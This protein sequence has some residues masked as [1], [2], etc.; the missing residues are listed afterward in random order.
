MEHLSLF[1]DLDNVTIDKKAVG[2]L[3]KD[4]CEKYKI[5]PYKIEGDVLYLAS[6]KQLNSHWIR[7]LKFITKKNIEIS[8]CDKSQIINLIN[9]YYGKDSADRALQELQHENNSSQ[10]SSKLEKEQTELLK[11]P[12]ITLVDSIVY[13]AVVKGASDIHIEPFKTYVTVRYRVDGAL[14]KF[15]TYPKVIY[16]SLTT[17]IKIIS[18]M[19]I[20]KKHYPQDGKFSKVIND[21]EFDFRVSSLPTVNGEKF[22]I[23]VLHRSD[24]TLTLSSLGFKNKWCNVIEELLKNRQGLI[25]ITGPTGSGK[26]TTLYSMLKHINTS[27]KNLVTVED[28]VEYVLEGVNQVHVNNQSGLTFANTLKAILRQDPD[29][30]MVGEIIDEAT[31]ETAIRAALTGHLVLTTLHTNDAA[32]TVN[33]LIDMNIASYLISDSLLAVVAQ[34]LARKVCKSC[35]ESYKPNKSERIL[36]GINE[37]TEL[38]KG[39]GCPKCNG[40]GYKGRVA[41]YEIML[42]NERHKKIICSSHSSEDLKR[43]SMSNGMIPLKECFRQLVINGDTT[44][45]E[46]LCNLQEFNLNQVMEVNYAI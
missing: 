34:R 25:I 38:Y 33:R 17:R 9:Y 32:S 5:F 10:I 30:I 20:S 45:E 27:Y 1:I 40:T 36:L 42:V 23:R 3:T 13:N 35:K 31:A 12:V 14:E 11:G 4:L 7:E 37:G 21:G 22:V 19:D 15:N 24:N 6:I 29:V 41:V 44:L 2:Y 28:P 39:K 16:D 46:Y 26:T 8:I 18:K 43:Y